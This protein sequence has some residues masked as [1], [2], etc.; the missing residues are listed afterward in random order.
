MRILSPLRHSAIARVWSALAFS[1]LGDELYAVA[2]GWIAVGVLGESAGYLS[3]GRAAVVL[4]TAIFGGGLADGWNRQRTMVAADLLRA[5][6][7]AALVGTWAAT[8]QPS[9]I[10]LAL[11]VILL[12]ACEAFFEPALQTILPA[13]SPKPDMLVAINGL[14]DATDRLARLLGPSLIAVIGA[15]VA[16]MHFLTLDAVSFAISSIAV[17]TLRVPTHIEAVHAPDAT[18]W[19]ASATR[20]FTAMRRD[21]LLGYLLSISGILNGAWYAVFYLAVPLIIAQ[22]GLGGG[23]SAG[24]SVYGLVIA[25]YGCSNLA[26]NLI[27]GSRPLPGRPA[28]LIFSGISLTGT[29]ILL[30]GV[31]CLL[32][33]Q[34]TTRVI[35]LAIA[36]AL[37]G[38][39]GPLQDITSVTLR[40]MLIPPPDMAAAMRARMTI[41]YSGML[42]AMLIAPTACAWF[43][44]PSVTVFSGI[45]YLGVAAIG[46]IRFVIR[47]TASVV[48]MRRN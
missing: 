32:P 30:I 5:A 14:F 34:P 8:G 10:L 31:I 48:I 40:Q 27:V 26:A 43:G 24:L 45:V 1:A 4:L 37:S 13:L 47:N 3:A 9:P 15:L 23:G 21:P 25:C 44:A 7:L 11:A 29:G 6:A 35:A 41:V 36:S 19:R 22:Q 38:F 16:P 46:F 17:A 20:G 12:A 2:I 18:G 28:R 33:L 42:I 39:G